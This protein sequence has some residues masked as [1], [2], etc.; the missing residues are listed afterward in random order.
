M[1]CFVKIAPVGAGVGSVSGGMAIV[2]LQVGSGA[3]GAVVTLLRLVVGGGG[4]GLMACNSASE[5]GQCQLQARVLGAALTG[6]ATV[7]VLFISV[8]GKG[9]RQCFC[10]YQLVVVIRVGATGLAMDMAG[11]WAA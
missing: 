4:T 2:L 11:D 1:G 3:D 6:L 5:A 9:S 7:G 10:G 8:L